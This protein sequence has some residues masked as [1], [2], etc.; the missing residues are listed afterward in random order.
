MCLMTLDEV[1]SVLATLADPTRLRVLYLLFKHQAREWDVTAI[2]SVLELPQPTVS[3]HLAKLREQQLV[4]VTRRGKHRL[5]RLADHQSRV[6]QSLLGALEPFVAAT[7]QVQEDL[8]RAAEIHSSTENHDGH[9]TGQ[10][11]YA[12]KWLLDGRGDVM[13]E[14][15]ETDEMFRAWSNRTR[16]VLLDRIQSEPGA[17]LAEIGSG[18]TGTRQAVRKHVDLLLE[19]GLVHVVEDG[20]TRRLY[21]NAVPLQELYD[22]WTDERSSVLARQ[23]LAVRDAVES[24]EDHNG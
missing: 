23:V 21:Y 4:D 5:Y 7:P 11:Q 16:R 2:V 3:R 15:G 24:E 10:F 22:R 17:T 8:R 6:E 9:L 12:T 14:P 13:T 19:A 18:V 20:R 1:Q